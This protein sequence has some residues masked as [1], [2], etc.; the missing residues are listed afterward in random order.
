VIR[1]F[2]ITRFTIKLAEID[3]NDLDREALEGIFGSLRRLKNLWFIL[4]TSNT[5]LYVKLTFLHNQ[6]R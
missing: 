3:W 5:L 1:L 2:L 6:T 4:L